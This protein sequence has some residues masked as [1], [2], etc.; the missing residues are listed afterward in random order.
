MHRTV[1]HEFVLQGE[2]AN[3]HIHEEVTLNF[4]YSPV[5]TLCES[6]QRNLKVALKRRKFHDTS[7][8]QVDCRLHWHSYKQK[9][10]TNATNNG[11]KTGLTELICKAGYVHAYIYIYIYIP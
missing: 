5:L 6:S 10:L 7:T 2:I 3:Q 1:H 4:S 8:I 9:K 11:A